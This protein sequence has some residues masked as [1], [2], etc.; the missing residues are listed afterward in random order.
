[1]TLALGVDTTLGGVSLAGWLRGVS[2]RELGTSAV[3]IVAVYYLVYR[4]LLLVKGTRAAQMLVGLVLVGGAFFVARIFE[5]TTLLWLLDNFINYSIIFFIV[6]FQHDIRR[7]LRSVGA[8]LSVWGRPTETT[9]VFEEAVQAAEQLARAG[10]GALIVFEREATLDDFLRD[11]GQ[12]IDAR[13][14]RELLVALFV[15]S[16]QNALH[17]GAVVIRNLRLH[18]AGA[19]LP[20]SAT[21]RLEK[22]H[23]TR[24]RAALGITEETDAVALVV[25]EERGTLSLCV[26]GDI[27]ADLDGTTLRARLH[28]LLGG[29]WRLSRSSATRPTR[30]A[31]R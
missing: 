29:R 5:L 23:G 8:N 13:V 11:P 30:V 25:S 21:S 9:E 6:I 14:S 16:P 12:A 27:A 17:D 3:D 28:E 19:V 22:S 26:G 15:P 18:R 20:L 4:A 7:A 24:H 2:L 31:Q 1:M 10:L